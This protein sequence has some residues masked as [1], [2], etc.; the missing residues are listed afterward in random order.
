MG[1]RK[2]PGSP[3][4][5]IP[6]DPL[7]FAV[8]RGLGVAGVD[9]VG[10]GALCGPVVAAAVILPPGENRDLQGAGLRDSKQL[11]PRQRQG[12]V[13]HI[14]S[15]AWD[16][17]LGLASVAEID[18]LNILQASLLAMH[19]AIAKLQPVPQ[20]CWIDGNQLIPGLSLPQ[21]AIIQ[22]DRH[23]LAIAAASVVAKVWRDDLMVRLD[24]HYPGYGIA[25]HK[26]YGTAQHRSALQRLGVSPCHRRSFAPCRSQQLPLL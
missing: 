11:S 7:G 5:H 9:E 3:H 4:R 15:V 18:R 10:R 6:P 13:G 14:R 17:Q 26:G 16:C 8:D 25:Q 24:S 19:R 1:I 20:W 12:L 22:G 21:R 23:C 2:Q